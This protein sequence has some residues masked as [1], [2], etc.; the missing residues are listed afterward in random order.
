MRQH[1][2]AESQYAAPVEA[3]EFMKA[4][5]QI[6]EAQFQIQSLNNEKRRLEELGVRHKSDLERAKKMKSYPAT[7]TMLQEMKEKSD[8]EIKRVNLS[9][10]EY[11]E[12]CQKASGQL[13]ANGN[14]QL[15]SASSRA[16]VNQSEQPAT[17]ISEKAR[18]DKLE[19]EL[20]ELKAAT[21]QPQKPGTSPQWPAA[22]FDTL[23]E[24]V[25]S[26]RSELACL[27]TWK[28][29]IDRRKMKFPLEAMPEVLSNLPQDLK[30]MQ[31]KTEEANTKMTSVEAQLSKMT[32]EI[33]SLK[34][35]TPQP[36]P[37]DPENVK[38]LVDLHLPLHLSRLLP[39]LAEN[40]KQIISSQPDQSKTDMA[41]NGAHKIILD[42]VSRLEAARRTQE[43]ALESRL[44]QIA[45]ERSGSSPQGMNQDSSIVQLREKA[46]KIERAHNQI[47]G[48]I[49]H[50]K[51][52]EDRWNNTADSLDKAIEQFQV[53][54]TG[55][56]SLEKRYCNINTQDMVKQMATGIMQSYSSV[57]KLLEEMQAVKHQVAVDIRILNDR[58]EGLPAQSAIDADKLNADLK[59]LNERVDAWPAQSAV[60]SKRISDDLKFLNERI[61]A[62]PEQP[63]IDV[64]QVNADLK[65][66]KERIDELSAPPVVD[67]DMD[68]V[69]KAIKLRLAP[70]ER[71]RQLDSTN[72]N[73]Q[74]RDLHELQEKFQIHS[75][76]FSGFSDETSSD[77][78]QLKDVHEELKHEMK[79]LVQKWQEKLDGQTSQYESLKGSF[80]EVQRLTDRLKVLEPFDRIPKVLDSL[81]SAEELSQLHEALQNRDNTVRRVDELNELLGHIS[82][83]MS[84]IS[85]DQINTIRS[86]LSSEFAEKL[87]SS[88]TS[89]DQMNT[90]RSQLSSEL[91]E[92]LNMTATSEE[93]MNTLRSQ[94]SNEL[95][96]KLNMSAISED[97]LNTIRSQ[98]SSE[99]AEK[100]KEMFSRE[101]ESIA[102]NGPDS[103]NSNPHQASPNP[104]P[105]VFDG[106]SASE[107]PDN[108]N[109]DS[110]QLG[111]A[112]STMFEEESAAVDDQNI[113][114][115]PSHQLSQSLLATSDY[116]F[117]ANQTLNEKSSNTKGSSSPVKA[118][119]SFVKGS[120]PSVKGSGSSAKGSPSVKASKL[121]SS[122]KRAKSGSSSPGIQIQGLSS[123]TEKP[124]SK[125]RARFA[126]SSGD[127]N[128]AI[129]SSQTNAPTS[130]S[131][132][133]RASKKLKKQLRKERRR[134]ARNS[135]L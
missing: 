24:S 49:L 20:A 101:R 66:L 89:E 103:G 115:S 109:S 9:I 14:F 86:Q 10:A 126:D 67:V 21:T 95:V 42:R 75:T 3:T 118:S 6:T 98:L 59:I 57:P 51:A 41:D 87:N 13:F 48:A 133:S 97:N 107:Q 8:K 5:S 81:G 110:D 63:A 83:E 12:A 19:K 2:G 1:G 60:D 102:S 26:Q 78:Q 28:E 29:L 111:A 17:L 7:I 71:S 61:N 96:E 130:D 131:S 33:N 74:L 132:S 25:Q 73:K 40:M 94:L 47:N 100:L 54:R 52:Q 121:V 70:I 58:I 129:A 99:L 22:E 38:R 79:A 84:A 88:A 122:L 117:G 125:K 120:S 85:E 37:S 62:L 18:I 39:S 124:K 45:T 53:C 30:V 44:N 134:E 90:I 77:L 106:A 80:E 123:L 112:I 105:P 55:L 128:S 104:I 46:E 93:Q 15:A 68:K 35:S 36:H 64:N 135:L 4:F 108:Q 91:A 72:I 92:K 23:R 32:Q 114:T 113:I 34:S 11:Q 127:E 65:S 119:G 82:G 50:L 116:N 76:S 27:K 69:D 43:A 16:P 31:T 56:L